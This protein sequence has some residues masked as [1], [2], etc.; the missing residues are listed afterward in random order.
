MNPVSIRWG[1]WYEDRDM[2]LWF[3]AGWDVTECRPHDGDDIGDAGL[4]GELAQKLGRRLL[5][6]ITQC[7]DRAGGEHRR[8]RLPV[9][10]VVRRL[11]GQQ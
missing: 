8:H 2:E 4:V 11:D 6:P 10:R 5:D 1:A 3:P 9:A 7:G